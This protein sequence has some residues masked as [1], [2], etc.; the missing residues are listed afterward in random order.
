MRK[1]ILAL[2]IAAGLVA[3]GSASA[4]IIS[5]E[6]NAQT[7]APTATQLT[8]NVDGL[9]HILIV[10]YFSAQNG[11]STLINLVNTDA[12]NG[13]AV[14]VRFRGASNSDDIFDFQVFLSPSDVW[15]ANIS[16]VN[17]VATLSTTDK[18]CTLPSSVNQAFVLDRLPQTLSVADQQKQTL[19]GYVEILNMANIPPA[20]YALAQAGATP[21]DGGNPLFQATVHSNGVPLCTATTMNRLEVDALVM[22]DSTDTSNAAY[23][24]LDFPSGGLYANWTIINV[25]G[26]TTWTGA[27]SAISAVTAGFVNG[28]G[29]LVMH[30]QTGDDVLDPQNRTSDPILTAGFL[31]ISAAGVTGVAYDPALVPSMFDFPDLS[32]PYLPANVGAPDAQAVSITDSLAVTSVINEYL[33]DPTISGETDWVF[34]SPTR[35]YSVGMDYTTDPYTPVFQDLGLAAPY[36]HSANVVVSDDTTQLCVKGVTP[37]AYDREERTQQGNGFVISPGKKTILTFCG[38]VSVLSFA[39]SG[40]SVLGAEL[41][42]NNIVSGLY[43]DGWMAIATPGNAGNG[44]PVI[45]ASFMSAFNPAVSAGVAGN[46]GLTFPHRFVR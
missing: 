35:R 20:R 5:T 4:N 36:F 43:Q 44:L 23:Q 25:P 45:G 41:T 18:S 15:T 31:T 7:V 32:T 37:T 40:T 12:V 21:T 19:E 16:K 30:P 6:T 46:F 38:E 11:N 3:A 33:T 27:A 26:S 29:N 1:N 9:G 24:G 17:G 22:D 2:S 39:N 34:S 8:P 14:K 10:P 13:K 42:R 28:T